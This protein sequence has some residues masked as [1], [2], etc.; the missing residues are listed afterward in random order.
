MVETR[1]SVIF[2]LLSPL[3]LV[4]GFVLIYPIF[5]TI[6]LSFTDFDIGSGRFEIV[7]FEN[8][9]KIVG[10]SEFSIAL[11]NTII[12]VGVGVP[13]QLALGILLALLLNKTF[14]LRGLART[15]ILFPFAIPAALNAIIWRWMYNTDYGLFNDL[16]MKIGII[17][18]PINWLGRPTLAMTSMIIVS[19]WKNASYMGLL[20][21]AGLQA[22]PK[23]VIEA[24]QIDGARGW[25]LVK[26]IVLPLL[27][28][29]IIVALILR[30]IDGFKAFELPFNLTGG[31]PGISTQTLALYV[32]KVLFQYLSFD[33]GCAISTF[34][35]II[36][37][38]LSIAYIKLLR[39]RL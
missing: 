4:L 16:L 35:F 29:V 13:I 7:G 36:L 38:L 34:Y 1:R 14:K 18:S 19:I 25:R 10:D 27:K 31:G 17:N 30:T 12:F 39:A 8:Y 26:D 21:L 37:M 5:N 28:P 23:E 11:I 6:F 9:F 2:L 20:I 24:A 33:Y 15:I 32:Y 22:I 3:F